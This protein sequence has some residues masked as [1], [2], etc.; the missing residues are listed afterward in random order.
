MSGKFPVTKVFASMFCCCC[1][2]F[3]C[4]RDWEGKSGAWRCGGE[5]RS[6]VCS[7]WKRNFDGCCLAG[8]GWFKRAAPRINISQTTITFWGENPFLIGSITSSCC[9][10]LRRHSN[11]KFSN[12]PIVHNTCRNAPTND[13]ARRR[14]LSGEGITCTPGYIRPCRVPLMSFYFSHGERFSS[15]SLDGD[16][17]NC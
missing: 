6:V 15:S 16:A 5:F 17:L 1:C 13:E 11:V 7:G 10:F 9:F 3:Q 14:T 8:L 2:C 4:S 12:L